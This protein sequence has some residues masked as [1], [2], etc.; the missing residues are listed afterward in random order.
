M[1][2]SAH[3]EVNQYARLKDKHPDFVI[4]LGNEIYLT[5]TRDRGQKY[6]HFILIAKG[7]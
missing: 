5:D 2:L 6:Y 3:M 1:N 4:A 7:C